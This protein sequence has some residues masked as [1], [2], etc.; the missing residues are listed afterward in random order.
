LNEDFITPSKNFGIH[1]TAHKEAITNYIINVCCKISAEKKIFYSRIIKNKLEQVTEIST[2]KTVLMTDYFDK[3]TIPPEKA[4]KLYTFYNL[5]SRYALSNSIIQSKYARILVEMVDRIGKMCDLT[6]SF[7][8]WTDISSNF[9]YAFLLHKFEDTNEIINIK[10]FS[11]TRHTA[12][13]LLIAVEN[14]LK[15]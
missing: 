10:D 12:D 15:N 3:S 9:I 4:T 2:H 1:W 5:P 6:L 14:S 11:S 7:D 13:N 8:G